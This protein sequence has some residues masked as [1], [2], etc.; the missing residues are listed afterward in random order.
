MSRELPEELKTNY[1][2][3]TRKF[4][5]IIEQL[6][7]TAAL[8][9]WEKRGYRDVR[10]EVPLSCGGGKRVFVKVLARDAESVV[11]VECASSIRLSWLRR[12]IAALRSCL[13]PDS[14][15]IIIFPSNAGECADKAVELADEVWVT[16]KDNTQVEQMMFMSVF[17]IE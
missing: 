8:R 2:M 13:P 16:G 9:L 1:L 15:L 7:V 6:K 11:A 3:H 10:F 14:Y 4:S 5:Y 12:R 17:H